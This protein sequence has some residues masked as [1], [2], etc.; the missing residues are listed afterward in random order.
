M[1]KSGSPNSDG[2]IPTINV[3]I[4]KKTG[5]ANISDDYAK[6]PSPDDKKK[7]HYVPELKDIE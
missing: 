3:T 7:T 6:P 1:Q 5:D 2:Q 4:D